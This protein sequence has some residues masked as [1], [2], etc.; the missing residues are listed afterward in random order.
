VNSGSEKI[1]VLTS[2]EKV[3]WDN[4]YD[5]LPV[6]LR[7]VNYSFDY[8]FIYEKN[9]DG[10]IRLFVFEKNDQTY[11]YP[12]LIRNV[13]SGTESTIY[14]DIETVYGYTGPVSTTENR[15]FIKTADKAFCDYCVSEKIITE[16]IRFNPLL[17]NQSI[18][19]N[20]DSVTTIALRDYVAVELLQSE[21]SIVANYSSQNRNKIRKAENAGIEI[22]FDYECRG[23]DDFVS[24]YLENMKRLNAAPMYFFSAAFF[25][26]L[27][28]L[29][30]KCG[31]L[32]NAKEAGETIGSTVF[33][34]GSSYGHY[35]LSSATE[36]GRSHAVSNL[37]LHHGILW[38]KKAGLKSIHLGGGVSGEESDPLLVFKKNFSKKTLKFYIGKR[39]HD[40]I[41]YNEIVKQWDEK[42]PVEAIKYKFILQRYR[43]KE[44]DL[45]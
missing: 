44:T 21:E 15:D 32:V 43:F 35:F 10:S 34:K 20:I 6:S 18:F 9:G 11:F 5:Q 41:A 40:E 30:K 31:V 24:I 25:E 37:M 42:H 8:N 14:K 12:F 28:S 7:D 29:T 16:F 26:E 3:M 13:Y 22:E 23:F 1:T 45:V 2:S 27:K 38:A 33:L 39:I 4:F 17:Q 36:K 19:E